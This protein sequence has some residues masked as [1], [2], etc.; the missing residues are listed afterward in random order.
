MSLQPLLNR[1]A[2]YPDETLASWFRRLACQNYIDPSILLRVL[3]SRTGLQPAGLQLDDINWLRH[4]AAMRGLAQLTQSSITEVY[5]HTFHRFATCLVSPRQSLDEVDSFPDGCLTFW[6]GRPNRDFISTK[7]SWCP[8]CLSEAQY[9]RQHWHIPMSVSCELHG[10]WLLERCP[11]CENQLKDEDFLDGRCGYCTFRLAEARPLMLSDD[12]LLRPMQTTLMSWLQ[13]RSPD[14]QLGLP[15]VPPAVLIAIWVGLRYAAQRAGNGWFFYHIPDGIPVPDLD[16]VKMRL[17]TLHERACLYATAFRG[18]L[19]WPQGFFSYLDAYR[20]RPQPGKDLTGMQREFGLLHMSWLK[21]YWKHPAFDFV[22]TAFNDYLLKHVP[23]HHVVM[24][25]R[26][27]DYP[28]LLEQV[29]Y[30][31]QRVAKKRFG[32]SPATVDRLAR[33]GHLT[34]HC[35]GQNDDRWLLRSELLQL[36]ERWGNH[37][38]TLEAGALLGV[39]T[40]M[41]YGLVAEGLV[42]SVPKDAGVRFRTSRFIYRDSILEFI[43]NL[44]SHTAVRALD[45]NTGMLLG[46][47]GVHGGGAGFGSSELLRLVCMGRVSASHPHE[48]LFPLSDLWFAPEVVENFVRIAKEAQ[49]L[50]SLT[51]TQHAL[52]VKR[53]T[54]QHYVA[55][56]LLQPAYSFGPKQFFRRQDVLALRDRSVLPK[57]AARILNTHFGAISLLV[58]QKV[59]PFIAGPGINNGNTRY[60]FDR[61]ELLRWHEEYVSLGELRKLFGSTGL[62]VALKANHLKS[63]TKSPQ[64]Y[65]RKEVM[66]V[67][68]KHFYRI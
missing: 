16:I 38:T 46:E 34:I 65:R 22:Q 17:L 67:L 49:G 33:E 68:K 15:K 32:I 27:R 7:A 9:V 61:S 56:N 64:V 52:D 62:Q 63:I 50:M 10:C 57:E 4:E 1:S 43:Q 26:V 29:E 60:R 13:G 36:Q 40:D 25:L 48:T 24:S 18:L 37:L 54:V 20:Q 35:F 14:R 30:V 2:P 53:V 31:K 41:I 51:E 58:L 39:S 19:D 11:R 42:Q 45:E 47:V 28:E 55:T 5:N 23:V 44:K 6:P 59:L 12:D 3:S 8:L 21:Q 66:P